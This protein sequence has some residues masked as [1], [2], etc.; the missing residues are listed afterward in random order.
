MEKALK[1]VQ[2]HHLWAAISDTL[3]ES[4]SSGVKLERS[5]LAELGDE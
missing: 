3:V 5:D 4:V 2:C 1:R